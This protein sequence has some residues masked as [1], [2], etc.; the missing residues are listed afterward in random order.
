ML[1]P[2]SVE[3]KSKDVWLWGP[4]QQWQ[5]QINWGVCRGQTNWRFLNTTQH[6]LAFVL[7]RQRQR[8]G[9][10]QQWLDKWHG[11]L[12]NT[13]ED[14]QRCVPVIGHL[15]Q[16]HTALKRGITRGGKAGRGRSERGGRHN[17]FG[18]KT[19]PQIATSENWDPSRHG[20]GGSI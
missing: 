18:E 14:I 2:S 19:K 16:V 4:I 3:M 13:W 7:Q 5:T 10:L 20:G 15:F 12:C 1:T 8:R 11:I 17:Q 9:R 6:V